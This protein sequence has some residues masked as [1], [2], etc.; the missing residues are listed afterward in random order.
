MKNV[1]F[2]LFLLIACDVLSAERLVSNASV[3]S[4]KVYETNDDSVRVWMHINGSARIGP[5]PENPEV[6]CELWTNSSLV[7]GSALAALM[8]K[9]KVNI[10]YADRGEKSHWCKVK[11]LEVLDN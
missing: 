11:V 7:H 10:W 6:T 2:M 8:G 5:N 1:F 4:L 3:T 9:K